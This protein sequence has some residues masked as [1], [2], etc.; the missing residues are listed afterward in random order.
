MR[1]TTHCSTFC[2]TSKERATMASRTLAQNASTPASGRA[3][4]HRCPPPPEAPVPGGCCPTHQGVRKGLA[5][6][7]MVRSAA[8]GSLLGGVWRVWRVCF[9]RSA[10]RCSSP[11]GAAA[12]GVRR[13]ETPETR[14][15][16]NSP[17]QTPLPLSE[18][19][20]IRLWKTGVRDL[21]MELCC[22]LH[23]FRVRLTPWQ[24]MV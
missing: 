9:G 5:C 14:K 13:G 10:A 8:P 1:C 18:K 24:P 7:V 12:R 19:S 17:T 23:N 4:R 21:V 16:P 3:L 11:P 6:T 15:L 22:A 20:R 2:L